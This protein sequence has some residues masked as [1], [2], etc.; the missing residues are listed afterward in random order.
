MNIWILAAGILVCLVCSAFFSSAEMS[1]S[2]CNRLRLENASE[3][4]SKK[5]ERA[6]KIADRFEDALSAI[7]IGN[8]LANIAGSSIASILVMK[9]LGDGYAWLATLVMTVLIII[10]SETVP[11]IT[12]KKNAT[13]LAMKYS[14]V[15]RTLMIILSP[16]V[17]LVVF[18]VHAITSRIKGPEAGDSDE[19]VEELQSIIETAEDEDIIDED[20]SELVQAAIDFSDISAYQVMTARVDVQALDIDSSYEELLEFVEQANY[21]RIP[22]YQD[23][24]DNVVGILYLNRFLKAIADGSTADIRSLM[25]KPCFVYKTVKLPQV[26]ESLRKAKQHLAIVSDEYGGTLGV[27]SMEDVLEQIVGDIWDEDDEYEPDI[28]ESGTDGFVL[29]GDISIPDFLELAEIP[30]YDFEAE[31]ETLGGWALEML[32][33]FPEKGESFTY[34]DLQITVLEVEGRRVERLRVNRINREE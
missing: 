3:G 11:K 33:G 16:V 15:V 13:N 8:N 1:Y 21:T 22:V 4:G 14:A 5:A 7:L 19:A 6:V 10:F 25:M 20:R 32:E 23:S 9:L 24:I 29:D 34:G 28:I 30:E 27:I 2:A 31:S 26:L 18:L 12:A 17:K